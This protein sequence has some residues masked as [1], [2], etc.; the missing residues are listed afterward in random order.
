MKIQ[1]KNKKIR[2]VLIGLFL[3]FLSSGLSLSQVTID[4]P[5]LPKISSPGLGNTFIKLRDTPSTYLGSEGLCLKVNE[6]T[7]QIFFDVCET[8]GGGGDITAVLAGTG[9]TGGGTSGSVTLNLNTTFTD[10]TYVNEGDGVDTNAS[11]ICSGDEVLLGNGSC[12]SSS[13]FGGD[14][15]NDGLFVNFT[16]TKTTGNITNGTLSG[17]S[18][19]NAICGF[20]VLAGSHVCTMD[21]ILNS[22]NKNITNQ[23]FTATFRVSEGAPGFTAEANDCDG[24]TSPTSSALGSIWVGSQS[25]ANTY[26]SGSLVSCS[27]ERAIGCCI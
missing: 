7:S 6:T 26:G 14:I 10:D 4:N 24:W 2:F 21:E 9:L 23:N 12:Q 19:A 3:I 13:D 17:Y 15:L 22:I 5:N 25:H 18:A 27:T 1:V 8:G 20:E 11:T 16:L